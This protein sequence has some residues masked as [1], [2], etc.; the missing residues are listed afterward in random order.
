MSAPAKTNDSAYKL[1]PLFKPEQITSMVL[2][3][4]KANI[5]D[6]YDRS[7]DIERRYEGIISDP[8][9]EH[10]V[11]RHLMTVDMLMDHE[12]KLEDALQRKHRVNAGLEEYSRPSNGHRQPSGDP[13]Q[14]QQLS[15]GDQFVRSNE[16]TKMRAA[17]SFNSELHRNEFSVIMSANTSLVS[18]QKALQ[19]KALIY[20]G[21]GVAGSLVQNDVQQGVLS[22]LQREINVLDLVPRLST[23]SDT[24]EYVREEVF[25]NQAAPVAE[26]TA[27][28]GTTGTKPESTLT[29][30]TQT[31]PVRTIAHWVP[32]TNK[33]LS[34]APQIRG[35]IN[36][37]LL[38]G[39]T[40]TLETQIISGNGVGENLTGI[41]NSGIQTRALGA[42]TVLDAIFR[43]RT[44]VRVNGK[45]RPT[46]IV[47]HP[48]DWE[49]VRLARENAASA[50][51]G[52]YLMGPPSMVGANTLWGLPVVESEA[53]TEN[54]TLVGDFSMGCSL[55]DR[56]QAVIRVGFINDQFIRNMQTILAELRA[57]FVVWRPTAFARVTG[58]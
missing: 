54:T 40:L 20:S 1:E 45:A 36:T 23:D 48:N 41:L 5:K 7:A 32:V 11:K 8:E 55:F 9:D 22:I 21:T 29:F 39:L 6:Q 49:A 37:R 12:K 16:Y 43:A 51:Y 28:T 14:G 18:W 35:I 44:M 24:I 13:L 58:V 30:S 3:E 38:L 33:T 27:T 10:Q 34:D 56:E 31:S 50:T 42:D 57:A 2:A 46:A 47:M 25:D 17:G 19:H 26:A 53:M 52:G 15:P 4:V